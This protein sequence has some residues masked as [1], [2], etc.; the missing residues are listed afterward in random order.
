MFEYRGCGWCGSE[1][2]EHV[3]VNICVTGDQG[4]NGPFFYSLEGLVFDQE[5]TCCNTFMFN[6]D[7]PLAGPCGRGNHSYDTCVVGVSV[8]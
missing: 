8:T 5:V 1:I 4:P 6:A 7:G 3:T 2:F